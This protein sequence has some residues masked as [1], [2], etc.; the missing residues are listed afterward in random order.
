LP[1]IRPSRICTV[2]LSVVVAMN[3][4]GGVLNY[5][6]SDTGCYDLTISDPVQNCR[7]RDVPITEFGDDR[8]ELIEKF[9]RWWNQ[10]RL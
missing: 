10:Q 3:L 8:Q 9:V 2:A 6:F 7:G 1:M 4:L 5:R